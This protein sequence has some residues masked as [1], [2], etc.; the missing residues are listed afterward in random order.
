MSSETGDAAEVIGHLGSQGQFEN[1]YSN[2]VDWS[3][4]T[5]RVRESHHFYP[6][7]F[8]F[9][10][11]EPYYEVSRTALVSLDTV[12]LIKSAPEHKEYGWLKESAA[13]MDLW[14]ATMQEL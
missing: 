11:R 9:R 13:V 8:F 6:M 10:F 1:G 12:S 5:A 3:A 14:R 2:V 4:E 7:F